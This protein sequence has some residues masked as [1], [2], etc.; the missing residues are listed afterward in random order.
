MR[1]TVGK[2]LSKRAEVTSL[3]Q[4]AILY[5][6]LKPGTRLPEIRLGR[7]LG[8]SQ[9]IVR[10]ALQELEGLGLIAKKP[11][12]GSYVIELD[13]D[14]L[15]EIYQ[16]RS[17]MEALACASMAR[18]YNH[19][20]HTTLQGHIDAMRAAAKNNDFLAYSRADVQFHRCI[21]ASQR[22]RFLERT[23]ETICLPLFAYDQI[24]R[25]ASTS[26]DYERVTRQHELI[27][28]ALR[29]G[30]PDRVGRLMK[31]MM[32]KWLRIHLSEYERI[33]SDVQITTNDTVDAFAYLR[34]QAERSSPNTTS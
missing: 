8:V 28:S 14:D 26:L 20:I 4:E 34:R 19:A 12:Q 15:V 1:T 13:A 11:G 33:S 2:T 10:E 25:A 31:R 30:D 22:N 32:H 27:V 3:L 5:G 7:E 17:E 6:H 24:R 29:T 23:L 21:W 9:A 16:V 18:V